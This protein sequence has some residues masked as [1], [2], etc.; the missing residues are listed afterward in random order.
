M[1]AEANRR[2]QWAVEELLDVRFEP[3]ASGAR[4]R[5]A[6]RA[7]RGKRRQQ[8][9]VRWRGAEAQGH[10][11]RWVFWDRLN[12]ALLREARAMWALRVAALEGA[13]AAART[14]PTRSSSRVAARNVRARVEA[15]AVEEEEEEEEGGEEGGAAEVEAEAV[16]REAAAA[17]R[18]AARAQQAA[19]PA[20]APSQAPKLVALL[21]H[22]LVG[23]T[24]Y[25]PRT[26]WPDYECVEHGGLAWRAVVCRAP[27][28]RPEV[29]LDF[30]YAKDEAG[31]AYK[32]WVRWTEVLR[33]PA[34]EAPV[35]VEVI[36]R[37]AGQ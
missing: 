10:E 2:G 20:A 19:A 16:A 7:Q 4:T 36:G 18:R 28:G 11:D 27:R 26:L 33:E 24:V 13:H 9:L 1:G 14:A 12:A 31:Q 8:A 29:C 5:A 6:A 15:E 30:T 21:A 35:G 3:R 37:E 32:E 22:P 25:V 23:D 34:G 17:R